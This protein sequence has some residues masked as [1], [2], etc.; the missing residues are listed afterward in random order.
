MKAFRPALTSQNER[1]EELDVTWKDTLPEL[2]PKK[3]D[4][5][6]YSVMT[7]GK[8]PYTLRSNA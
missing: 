3:P 4:A 8:N 7:T 1:E 5:P 2:D 6:Q